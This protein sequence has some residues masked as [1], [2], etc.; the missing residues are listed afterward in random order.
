[1]LSSGDVETWC[2]R[3]CGTAWDWELRRCGCCADTDLIFIEWTRASFGAP[4][5]TR[6]YPSGGEM[7]WQILETEH[8]PLWDYEMCADTSRD[9]VIRE[10]INRALKC[11]WLLHGTRSIGIC[12]PNRRLRIAFAIFTVLMFKNHGE[13]LFTWKG[14]R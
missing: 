11:P 5:P 13:D 9:A 2:A 4:C 7:I 12:S 14:Q 6:T 10:L 3:R 8:E 1:M